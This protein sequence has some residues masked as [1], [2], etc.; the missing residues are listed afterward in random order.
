MAYT[1]DDRRNFANST[2][3][4]VPG[5][6]GT[7]VLASGTGTRFATAPFNAT[8]VPPGVTP[9]R[10]SAEIVRVTG[11]SG[12]TLTVA[13]AQEGTLTKS[14]QAG[15]IVSA[16]PTDKHLDDVEGALIGLEKTRNRGQ[17]L[18]ASYPGPVPQDPSIVYA[19]GIFCG[20]SNSQIRL[21]SNGFSW[22][23]NS[24]AYYYQNYGNANSAVFF[25][26]GYFALVTSL[27][28]SSVTFYYGTDGTN[29][30]ISNVGSPQNFGNTGQPGINPRFAYGNT[31]HVISG[32]GYT[33]VSTNNGGTWSSPNNNLLDCRGLAFG[34]DVF[35]GASGNNK[36]F[37]SQNGTS[38]TE[39]ASG[40]SGKDAAYGPSGFV[41]VGDSGSIYRST[42]G[43]SNWTPVTKFTGIDFGSVH[44]CAAMG[45]YLVGGE[46]G[47]LWSSPDTVNWSPIFAGWDIT[48][49]VTSSPT[50]LIGKGLVPNALNTTY[51]IRYTN[52]A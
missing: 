51:G 28:S 2:V 21:S 41:V 8:V 27:G 52:I 9:T 11:K 4:N 10:D 39:R 42:N 45:L 22:A 34:A 14:I 35:V 43:V 23:V 44:Y 12:D 32:Y 20:L 16:G 46:V 47:V 3:A 18:D 1:F 24:N 25:G 17:W 26:G 50:V 49:I 19:A 37:S 31:R 36:I 5:T 15:W 6:G 33:Y 29:F 13:R 38:W 30:T 48:Q 7:I 40:I